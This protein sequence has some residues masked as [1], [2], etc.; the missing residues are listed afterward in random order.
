MAKQKDLN[1]KQKEHIGESWEKAAKRKSK[2]D[3]HRVLEEKALDDYLEEVQQG[4]TEFHEIKEQV[5]SC[6][7]TNVIHSA[8]ITR[9]GASH[10]SRARSL[11]DKCK[12]V[13]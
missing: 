8:K 12:S 7:V 5:E 3:A 10:I 6:D 4:A 11:M 9:L 1:D 13:V 2:Q